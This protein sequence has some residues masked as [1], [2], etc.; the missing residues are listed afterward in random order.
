MYSSAFKYYAKEE[1]IHLNLKTS[2]SSVER[3]KNTKFNANK[4]HA[5]EFDDI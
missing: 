2:L 1:Q 4:L 5:V 3:F